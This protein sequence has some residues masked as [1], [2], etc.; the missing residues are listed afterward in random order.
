MF[1]DGKYLVSDESVEKLVTFAKGIGMNERRLK[2]TMF[3]H[4]EL[5]GPEFRKAMDRGAQLVKS[6]DILGRASSSK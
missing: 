4:F 3:P 1:T 5:H 6:Q 2:K